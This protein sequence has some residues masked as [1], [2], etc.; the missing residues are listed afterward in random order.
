VQQAVHGAVG[1][2]RRSGWVAADRVCDE[3]AG[4]DQA[5]GEQPDQQ[6]CPDTG[7]VTSQRRA[8][9]EREGEDQQSGDDEGRPLHPAR[10]SD[11]QRADR[12]L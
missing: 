3:D 12:V 8:E 6:G 1:H 5:D 10:L 2:H 7:A 4:T 9:P 11:R